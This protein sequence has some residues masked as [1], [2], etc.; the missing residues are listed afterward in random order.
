MTDVEILVIG[1]IIALPCGL[2]TGWLV[3]KLQM[4]AKSCVNQ[5]IQK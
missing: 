2:L 1:C 3:N 5:E 4:K